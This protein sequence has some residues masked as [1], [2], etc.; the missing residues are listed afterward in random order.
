M[1]T[2]F[3]ELETYLKVLAQA[4]RLEL[5]DALRSPRTLDEIHLAPT[6]TLEMGSADRAMTRQGV[7]N[8]LHKLIDAG[9]VRVGVT[10]RKGRR[11]VHEYKLDTARLFA[12]VEEL[13][14]L[15]LQPTSGPIDPFATQQLVMQQSAA[16]TEGPKLVLVHGVK[17]G[18]AFPLHQASLREPRGWVIGRAQNLPVWIDYDPFVSLDHAEIIPTSSGFRLLDL[19]TAKNGTYLNWR[20]LAP[21]EDIP[22]ESGDVIGVGRTLLVFRAR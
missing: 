13:R 4:N 2:G 9:I 21:G 6:T 17:E 19:R 15:T 16:W 11:G 18:R 20:R 7:Q 8:H 1:D 5:L 22:L 3:G 14:K 10:D 12:V